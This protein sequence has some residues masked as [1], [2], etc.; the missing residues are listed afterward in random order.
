MYIRGVVTF[1][2]S[3]CIGPGSDLSGRVK[4]EKQLSDDELK[5]FIDISYIDEEGWLDAQPPVD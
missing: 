4:W 3:G 2:E 5:K 1:A